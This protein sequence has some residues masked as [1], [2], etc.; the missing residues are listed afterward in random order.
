MAIRSIIQ[1]G[2]KRSDSWIPL[3]LGL[4]PRM[5]TVP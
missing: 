2:E 3:R 1:M 5:M 4:M